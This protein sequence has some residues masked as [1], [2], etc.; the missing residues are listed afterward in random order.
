[1]TYFVQKGIPEKVEEGVRV[2]EGAPTP[3]TAPTT[4]IEKK[5]PHAVRWS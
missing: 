5:V 2:Q 3:T 4:P 1:M